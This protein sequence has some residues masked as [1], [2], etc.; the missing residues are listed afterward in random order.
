MSGVLVRE[1]YGN[2]EDWLANRKYIGGSEIAAMLGI[3]PFMSNVDLWELKTGRKPPKD[4]S[5]NAAVEYGNR[6]EPALRTLFAAEHPELLVEHHPF[7]ILYQTDF[8]YIRCTLDGDLTEKGTGR[9]GILEIKTVQCTNRAIWDAW[10][11]RVPQ[12]YY[13]QCIGQLVSTGWDFVD[14][15]AQLKKLNGDSVI[16][17]Y[18]F[19]RMEKLEDIE[20]LKTKAK[21]WW[22]GYVVND[23]KPAFLLPD[24]L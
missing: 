8:P 2:R 9:K 13:T 19:E 11:G 5:D 12:Y 7:D 18:H 21:Q 15:Y 20:W 17:R 4:L 6:L 14:L 1:H 3:S 22:E 23:I 24:V 16:K 10:N